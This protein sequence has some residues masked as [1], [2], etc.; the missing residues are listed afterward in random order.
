MLGADRDALLCD[1]AETY[2]IYDLK[3]LPVLTLA[4]LSFG[5]R[6]DS[7]IK[8]K[9][10]GL[11]YIPPVFL[12]ASTCDNIALLRY[13]LFASEND[14]LPTLYMDRILGKEQ[15]ERETEGYQTAEECQ[16][17]LDKYIIKDGD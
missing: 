9:L 4:A 8:M 1:L 10:A 11:T 2:H 12:L 6:E 5:L 16:A 7:R 3:A 15:P 17:A 13:N 14:G